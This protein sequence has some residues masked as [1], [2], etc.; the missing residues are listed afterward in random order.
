MK[1][2]YSLKY[3]S[4]TK[5]M[6]QAMIDKLARDIVKASIMVSIVLLLRPLLLLLSILELAL[7]QDDF[8]HNLVQYSEYLYTGTVSTCILAVITLPFTPILVMLSECQNSK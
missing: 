1:L 6:I 7:I 8:F 5:A 2:R 4:T 3:I